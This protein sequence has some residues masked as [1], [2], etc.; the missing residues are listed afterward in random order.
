MLSYQ[1]ILLNQFIVNTDNKV[2]GN[3][4]LAKILLVNGSPR[5]Y[6]WS[7][8]LLVAAEKGVEDAGGE[9]E[10]I[11]LIDYNIKPCIGCVSD[12]QLACRFPCVIE[13]DDFNEIGEK[14]LESD[15]LIISTPLYWYS[16]SGILKNFIDRMT[17]FENMIHH[18][19]RSLVDG[20]IAG[21]IA[22]GNDT[23]AIMA[24]AYLMVTLNSMGFLIPPW[25]LAYHHSIDNVLKN[26]S[27]VVDA[28]NVG[29]NVALIADKISDIDKWYRADINIDDII[30]DAKNRSRR[31]MEKQKPIRKRIMYKVHK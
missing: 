4:R 11:H 1:G 25:A 24:I 26:R 13:D 22:V 23:G 14:I 16:V 15:G 29:Y 5:K 18:T 9:A 10:I 20:K 19:G 7:F 27:A 28:Y 12:D 2:L 21:F 3:D 17:S 31:L 30:E 6:G 8:E